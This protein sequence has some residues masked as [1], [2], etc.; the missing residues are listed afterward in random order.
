LA[1]VTVLGAATTAL[2][3]PGKQALAIGSTAVGTWFL[4]L[5][6]HQLRHA[7][8]ALLRAAQLHEQLARRWGPAPQLVGPTA[9]LA[10]CLLAATVAVLVGGPSMV[11]F[12]VVSVV[13]ADGAFLLCGA[14]QTRVEQLQA[15][16]APRLDGEFEAG[17]WATGAAGGVAEA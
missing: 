14:L 7:V 9:G 1:L 17:L 4:S 15:S 2:G 10:V 16:A 5:A 6:T 3:S 8:G 13:V 12:G 11:V